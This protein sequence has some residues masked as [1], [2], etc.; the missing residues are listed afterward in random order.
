MRG[1]PKMPKGLP[2]PI[3]WTKTGRKPVPWNVD[4]DDIGEPI[5]SNTTNTG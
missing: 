5:W 4:L 2:R 1:E 3:A